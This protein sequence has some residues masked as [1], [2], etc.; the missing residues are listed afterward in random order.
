[1]QKELADRHESQDITTSF[2]S[3][4]TRTS[5]LV[6]DASDRRYLIEKADLGMP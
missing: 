1:M 4:L 3:C 2:G 6:I 5:H